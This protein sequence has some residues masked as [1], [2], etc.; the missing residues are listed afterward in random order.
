LKGE[1]GKTGESGEIGESGETG[2]LMIRFL[3]NKENICT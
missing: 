1:T 2:D 3:P